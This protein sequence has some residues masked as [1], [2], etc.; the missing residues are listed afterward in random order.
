VPVQ[1]HSVWGGTV[2]VK[3]SSGEVVAPMVA[4]T[5]MTRLVPLMSD[6]AVNVMVGAGAEQP[7]G[8]PGHDAPGPR[9]RAAAADEGSGDGDGGAGLDVAQVGQGRD[10]D[11]C[12]AVPAGRVASG[13]GT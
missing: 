3:V 8:G 1:Y 6:G 12:G 10:F 5:P 2:T 13:R 9:V 11:G 4:V 7:R